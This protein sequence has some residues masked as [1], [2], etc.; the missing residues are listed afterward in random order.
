MSEEGWR[1]FLAADGLDD[2]AVL[3]GGAVAVFGVGS[4]GSAARVADAVAG[5]PG[6]AGTG[7]V[8]TVS[9][10]AVSVRLTR[11]VWALE[12]HHVDLARGVSTAARALGATPDRA[13]IQEVQ[14]AVSAQPD[15]IA[16]P[17]WRAVLGYAAEA[18]DNGVDPLG[19]SSVVWMQQLDPDKPLRHAMHID[20][21]VPRDQ[22]A[23][24]VSAAV[25]AGGIVVAD[26]EAPESWILADAAG[27]KV[28]VCAWPDGAQA[29][30]GD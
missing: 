5:V 22:V 28:C 15:H 7:A 25:A 6:L 8:V 3:H 12:S 30:Q 9:D 11:D 20:V 1:A 29:D 26:D 10:S 23:A 18:D 4:L 14:V 19:H 2:W 17:F 24:R 27:N 13:A 21:S 16:L